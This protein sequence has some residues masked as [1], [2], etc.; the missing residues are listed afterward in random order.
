MKKAICIWK[1]FHYEN[2]IRFDLTLNETYYIV[3]K[4]TLYDVYDRHGEY[5]SVFGKS[6][7]KIIGDIDPITQKAL[8]RNRQIHEILN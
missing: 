3:E 6:T 5:I 7:F 4:Q 8:T 2:G 1:D